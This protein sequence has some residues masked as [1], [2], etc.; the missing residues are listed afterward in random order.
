MLSYNQL[1]QGFQLLRFALRVLLR[2]V[3]AGEHGV[4]AGALA[5]AV[6]SI[7][8]VGMFTD[9]LD[10]GM[11]H[12][13][14]E[15]L[16]ADLVVSASA[17]IAEGHAILAHRIGLTT[18]R[19]LTMRSVVVQDDAFQLVEAKAVTAHYPLRGRVRLT[20][21]VFGEETFATAVPTLGTA[22]V[23]PRLASALG[24]TIGSK[25]TLG[26]AELTISAFVSYE[27][28]RA[29]DVF[30][31]APRILFNL[32]DVPSTGLIQPGSRVK[33]RLLV[34]G[35][36][37]A[38][39]QFRSTLLDQ[40]SPGEELQGVEDARPEM[41]MALERARQFLGLA[42]LAAVL[43]AGVSIALSAH[44]Y[45][46]R[47]QDTAGLLRCFGASRRTVVGVFAV[48]LLVLGIGAGLLG[49]G[50]GFAAQAVLAELLSTLFLGGL[51][52]ASGAAALLGLGFS[53]VTLIGFGLPPLVKLGRI[54][55]ARVLRRD[56]V[57]ASAGN[58]V[59]YVA[60]V[61]TAAT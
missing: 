27:P 6:G 61:L 46:R 58:T 48:Q 50:L 26:R 5:I 29:G 10:Q 25:V 54:P 37:D 49:V 53:L 32:T 47:H 17:P 42:A 38:V 34:R 20:R 33:H 44:R 35:Q 31:I 9:R 56:D 15:L 57:G 40:L 45:A 36:A 18:A 13:A 41:R 1:N 52:A 43:L 21:E 51:P 2:E 14:A 24:L 19:T 59:T 39:R 4:L 16:G 3:R 30:S 60:A 28:D 8:A 11:T 22:W 23:D 55:P 12:Q 7:S